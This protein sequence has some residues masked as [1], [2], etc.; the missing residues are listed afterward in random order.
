MSYSCTLPWPP[1]VN[2][3]YTVWKGRKILS[4]KGKQ[5]KL[6]CREHLT[7]QKVPFTGDLSV[8]VRVSMPDKRRRDLDNLLKPILDVIGE[9]NVYE[10]DSQIV[11][12]RILKHPFADKGTVT[13]TVMEIE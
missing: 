2:T 3:Y 4:K 10:D 1:S 6:D 11:D 8:C 13:V 7:V 5:F 9:F 12:L